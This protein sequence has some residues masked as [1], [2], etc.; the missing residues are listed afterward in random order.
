M[1]HSK[2]EPVSIMTAFL[3]W[4]VQWGLQTWR[5]VIQ[6]FVDNAVI[7]G[8]VDGLYY[9]LP[10]HSQMADL[11]ERLVDGLPIDSWLPLWSS[12]A[13]A[14]ILISLTSVAFRQTDY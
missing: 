2:E 10:K 6:G 13:F 8:I 9:V 14:I 5:D 1:N 3:V 7:N 4:F 11:F 12:V